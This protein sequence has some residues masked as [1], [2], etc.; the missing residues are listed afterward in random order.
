MTLAPNLLYERLPLLLV[1]NHLCGTLVRPDAISKDEQTALV[2][3]DAI[4]D[5]SGGVLPVGILAETRAYAHVWGAGGWPTLL[6]QWTT[7]ENLKHLRRDTSV[8]I[9]YMVLFRLNLLPPCPARF[10]W[11]DVLSP[12]SEG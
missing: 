10:R 11:L 2:I 6:M 9:M 1:Y 5:V 12:E 4:M 3:L 7:R 8:G